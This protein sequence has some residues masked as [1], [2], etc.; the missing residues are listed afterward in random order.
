[1]I[2]ILSSEQIRN[3]D[4]YT[5][6]YEPISSIDL[7]ERASNAFVEQFVKIFPEK[8]PV[9]IFCGVGNNGGDGLAI[10]RLLKERGWEVLKYV[11]GNPK[12]GS[13]DFKKNLDRSE[14]YAVIKEEKDLTQISDDEIIIDGLFGS[15]LSRPLEGLFADAVNY[16]NNS[17]AKKVAI[18]IASGLFTEQPVA[19]NQVVFEPDFTISFQ[20][21]KLTFLLPETHSYVG[22]WFIVDVGLHKKFLENEEFDFALTEKSDLERLIPHRKK[23]THKSEVGK[24]L[25]ISG[26]KGKMGAAVLCT[27]AAFAAGASLINICSPSCGTDILQISIPE[28]MVIEDPNEHFITKIPKSSD[29]IVIG[30][31]L[32]TENKTVSAFENLMKKTEQPVVIDADAINILANKK[33]MLKLVPKD[34]ILTPHPGELKRLVGE[35]KN[36]F[37]KLEKLQKLCIKYQ[38]NVVLKGAFSAVCDTNGKIFFNPTGNPALAT[39]GSGDVLTGI[40]GAIVAQGIAPI[41]SLRLG[42]FVHGLAGDIVVESLNYFSMQASEIIH[43]IPSALREITK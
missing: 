12:K 37:E 3:W 42:V 38:I 27:K 4:Q 11:V 36:D 33:S 34:S 23:F 24:L 29:T 13:E 31:G 9:R 10:G 5:I 28:A 22:E 17:N 32:G 18:D 6:K 41:D 16:L 20:T 26:S 25:I 43:F 39:A 8:K 1:M 35:W 30:P 7:M 2:K 14:L 40:A 19:K 15:G 21:P